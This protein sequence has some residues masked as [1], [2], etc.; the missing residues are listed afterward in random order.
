MKANMEKDRKVIDSLINEA[1][2]LRNRA[3][4]LQKAQGGG[5]GI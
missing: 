4:E 5:G 2:R 3:M 1:D